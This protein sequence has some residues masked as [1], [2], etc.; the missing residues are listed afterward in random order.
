MNI[1][2]LRKS[3]YPE[4]LFLTLISGL[5]Y[6]P[7]I[8]SLTYLLDEWYFI[9][10][11]V[12]AGPNIFHP[13]FSIDRPARG[14]F[15]DIYFSL[16]GPVPFPYH[17]GA[18]LWR[19]VAGFCALRLFSIIWPDNRK[20]V[21]LIT[22]LFIL[23]P[24]YSW[25]VSAIEYQ[26]H[27]ASLA[28]QMFS[29]V[30][31]LEAIRSSRI[32]LRIVF[33]LLA[34][35]SGWA[36]IALV[37]YAIGMEIFRFL[38]VY[39]I[40]SRS[41]QS[42]PVLRKISASIRSWSW[43]A[44]IPLGF[45]FWRLFLFE[46][47]RKTTDI[48]LLISKFQSA[49]VDTL[50][51]W[52]EYFFR[53]V[54]TTGFYA[55]YEPF[56]IYFADAGFNK[57]GFW[58][59]ILAISILG[60]LGIAMFK[61]K[62]PGSGKQDNSWKKNSQAAILVG[63]ASLMSGVLP[64]VLANRYVNLSFYSYYGLP[65]SLAVAVLLMGLVSYLFSRPQIHL[66]IISMVIVLAGFTHSLLA[67]KTIVMENLLENFWWQASWRIPD[68]RPDSTLVTL[69]PNS[70]AIDYG[71]GL[72]ELANLIYFPEPQSQLPVRLPVS[73]LMPIDSDVNLILTTD[74]KK[75]VK[76]RVHKKVI[77][78]GNIVILVQ[79]TPDSCVRVIS[80]ERPI[81]SDD[82]P[83]NVRKIAAYS[84][85]ENI[86]LQADDHIP[87]EF[88][89]GPE[90]A[91][92]WCYFYEKAD[93]AVQRL[94]WEN[95]SELGDEALALG[96]YPADQVEWFPFIQAYAMTGNEEKL[97]FIAMQTAGNVSFKN[98]VCDVYQNPNLEP[99]PD[100]ENILLLEKLFCV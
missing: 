38:C 72:D 25:W 6:L 95:A 2:A 91:H 80:A 62:D 59:V 60:L 27:I 19:L 99:R 69:Y 63:S 7:Y 73:T 83:E 10:D 53:S 20:F 35:L 56:Y 46:N 12:V 54:M 1:H 68:L 13:M 92:E 96:F 17:L 9:Y 42:L 87:Q 67:K 52:S 11:G 89:F 88:A 31:T 24:G 74:N 43:N 58:M 97:E 22:L 3:P 32:S 49:P 70:T 64:I 4:L 8:T 75:S 93:L 47:Q 61:L 16:F 21:F 57:L 48:N 76:Y 71:L 15:F 14:Y 78:Y 26:P 77:N 81:F 90:P 82:D 84:K 5:V 18:Y 55:W 94:D 98:Q 100:L 28:L 86:R 34:I 45:I 36:Y 39:L 40:V 85:L 66:G 44:L 30:M 29:C 50:W 33:L 41:E 51:T 79:P 65:A 37:E 23:Y